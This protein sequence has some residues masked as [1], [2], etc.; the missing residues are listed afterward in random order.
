MSFWQPGTKQ[1]ADQ[2]KQGNEKNVPQ[3]EKK[4]A[5]QEQRSSGQTDKDGKA[6]L[7]KGVMTMK[8]MKRKSDADAEGKQMAEKRRKQLDSAWTSEG[9]HVLSVLSSL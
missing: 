9:M 2:K 1:P 8:F 3:I 4:S 5:P 6:T 7:S